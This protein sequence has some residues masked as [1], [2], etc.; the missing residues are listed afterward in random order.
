MKIKL[1]YDF[2]AYLPWEFLKLDTAV[3]HTAYYSKPF[4]LQYVPQEDQYGTK[5]KPIVA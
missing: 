4:W 3:K 5:G 2:S 1:I